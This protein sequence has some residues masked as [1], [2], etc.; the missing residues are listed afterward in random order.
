MGGIYIKYYLQKK[1]L[2][3][4]TGAFQQFFLIVFLPPI[5]FER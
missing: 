5:I 4:I 2:Q 1:T 3:T